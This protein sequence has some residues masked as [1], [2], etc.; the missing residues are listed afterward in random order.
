MNDEPLYCPACGIEWGPNGCDH[1]PDADG[2][3]CHTCGVIPA[4]GGECMFY[5]EGGRE[6]GCVTE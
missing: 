5:K 3:Y 4:T 2:P 6:D 1:G